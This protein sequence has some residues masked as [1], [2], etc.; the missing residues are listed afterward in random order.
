MRILGIQIA[1]DYND[2][3]V[4]SAVG[5]LRA[6]SEASDQAAASV[7][8]LAAKRADLQMLA[9]AQKDY[10]ATTVAGSDEQQ[11]ALSNLSK[12]EARLAAQIKVTGVESKAASATMTSGFSSG[13]KTVKSLAATFIGLGAAMGGYSLFKSSIKGA[14]DYNAAIRATDTAI[15]ATG[16][17]LAAYT[18]HL[19][20]LEKQAAQLG[21]TSVDMLTGFKNFTLVT[22]NATDAVQYMGLAENIARAKGL[23][24]TVV[25]NALGKAIDGKSTSLQR[26]GI[27][28]QK[29]ETWEQAFAQAGQRFSGQAQA[30]TTDMQK[31]SAAMFDFKVEI[32]EAVLPEVDKL[33]AKFTAWI[34]SAKNQ[35]TVTDDVKKAVSDLTTVLKD[36]RTIIADVDKVT[37]G[38]KNTLEILAG[39]KLASWAA[40]TVAEIASVGTAADVALGPV[41]ALIAALAVV[42]G[43]TYLAVKSPSVKPG[44]IKGTPGHYTEVMPGLHGGLIQITDAQA[45][46]AG[47]GPLAGA[48]SANSAM[49][50]GEQGAASSRAATTGRAKLISFAMSMLGTPYA[51]GGTGPGGFDCSGLVQWAFGQS[52]VQLPH[53][54]TDQ[55]KLG[56]S[57]PLSKIKPGDVVFTEKGKG[58]GGGPGHEGLYAGGGQV[59]EAPHPGDKVK[60]VSLASFISGGLAGIRDFMGAAGTKPNMLPISGPSTGTGKTKKAPAYKIPDELEAHIRAAQQVFADSVTKSHLATLDSLL[61][62]EEADLKAHGQ[63]AKAQSVANEIT[64]ANKTLTDANAKIVAAQQVKL[65]QIT[66]TKLVKAPSADEMTL[67]LA[68]AAKKPT[69]AILADQSSLLNAYESEAAKLKSDLA[70]ATGKAKAAYQSAL[71]KIQTS[72]T[73]TEDSIASSLESIAQIAQSGLQS[74]ISEIETAADTALGN[75]YSQNGLLTPAEAQFTKMQAEDTASSLAQGVASA[76]QALADD[77]N[78][79]LEEQIT[80]LATGNVKNIYGPKGSATQIAQDEQAINAAQRAITENNLQTQATAER[81]AADKAYASAEFNLNA[82]LELFSQNVGNGAN[83]QAEATALLDKFGISLG[84]STTETGQLQALLAYFGVSLGTLSDPGGKGLFTQLQSSVK[85]TIAAFTTLNKYLANPSVAPSAAPTSNTGAPWTG[86][87]SA[88]AF[89]GGA[90]PAPTQIPGSRATIGAFPMMASGG[91]ILREGFAY[92]HAGERVRAAGVSR[93]GGGDSPISVMIVA[94]NYIGSQRELA[95]AIKSRGVIESVATAVIMAGR[96]GHIRQSSL[97]T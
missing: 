76:Q 30:N 63:D 38:F 31:F 60:T 97:P 26:Y 13:M 22:G 49:Q 58:P 93:S 90:T 25:T 4:K 85:A 62:Q 28:L 40:A 96:R 75:Q 47:V 42:A 43:G 16:G 57:V 23:D 11:I 73:S 19:A 35:K 6:F 32:G 84:S 8:R 72:V 10:A 91:D 33:I 45:G 18:P 44:S 82:A 78:G 74:I 14:E 1:G 39:I 70:K 2:V 77:M 34:S 53:V 48:T 61:G 94:P 59:I 56:T 65:A 83:V 41:E 29:G 79:A 66:I 71:S 89:S 46:A 3:A 95:E 81:T 27:V 37:G 17:T 55:F 12:T 88:V 54:T 87:A 68:T 15:K 21:Y 92:L 9:A 5:D 20:A 69:E 7:Q 64:K 51:W 67:K 36:A 24:L 86:G 52:G 80:D 50:H